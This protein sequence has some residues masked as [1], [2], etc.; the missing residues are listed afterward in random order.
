MECPSVLFWTSPALFL[1]VSFVASENRQTAAPEALYFSSGL[2]PKLPTKI[3][4]FTLMIVSGT[5]KWP[6]LWFRCLLSLRWFLDLGLGSMSPDFRFHFPDFP[7]EVVRVCR[8]VAGGKVTT[9]SPPW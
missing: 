9:P 7:D 2:L 1:K 4:L 8:T 6:L 3:T 5:K